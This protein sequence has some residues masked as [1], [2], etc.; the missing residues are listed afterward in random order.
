MQIDEL[1]ARL[2]HHERLL[3]LEKR[4]LREVLAQ[5][6]DDSTARWVVDIRRRE[7]I[8]LKMRLQKLQQDEA[9]SKDMTSDRRRRR[10]PVPRS[11]AEAPDLACKRYRSLISGCAYGRPPESGSQRAT[12]NG[13]SDASGA[14]TWVPKELLAV[15]RIMRPVTPASESLS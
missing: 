5:Q 8:K 9:G 14:S 3:L 10:R 13:T 1:L 12:G 2:E 6:L 15:S 4:H 11:V 7:I